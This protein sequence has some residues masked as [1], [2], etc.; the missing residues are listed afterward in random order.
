MQSMK[1]TVQK[2]SLKIKRLIML[3]WQFSILGYCQ[4]RYINYGDKLNFKNE[5]I[6]A[7]WKISC[8]LIRIFWV[9]IYIEIFSLSL[10]H[11]LNEWNDPKCSYFTALRNSITPLDTLQICTVEGQWKSTF[12]LYLKKKYK[13][14]LA[15]LILLK[16]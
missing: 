4:N 7:D 2:D 12:P 13:D 9:P 6:Y 3:K 11:E 15:F 16:W 14:F 1:S 5:Y 10:H 8:F